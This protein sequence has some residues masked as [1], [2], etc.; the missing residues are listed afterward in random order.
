MHTEKSLH[1]NVIAYWIVALG[2]LFYFY[3]YFLRITPSVIG[4]EL[5]KSFHMD[6][7]MFGQLSA[8]Y[9]YA[10]TPMQLVVGLLIDRFKLRNILGL[11]TLCCVL[12][13]YL[14]ATT[15]HYQMAEFGRFLQ[16]FGS[17][18]AFV[19][20]LKLAAMWLPVKRFGL[21]SG[22]C[23]ALGFFGAA[24]G[25]M[26][27]T[28]FVEHSGWHFVL[29]VFAFAGIILMIALV[30]FVRENKSSICHSPNVRLSFPDFFGQIVA[31]IKKPRIWVAGAL[32]ALMF[33]PT[34]VFAGL[35]G[36]PY[37]C[38][39]HD[40]TRV[41]AG[42][43]SA[44]IFLGWTM[45]APLQGWISDLLQSRVRVIMVG[46]LIGAILSLIVLYDVSLSYFSVCLLF[47]LFGIAS[48]SQVLTFAIARDL[49]SAA[50]A[51]SAIA[52]VNTLAMVGG[53][54]FQKGVGQ[55]LDWNWTGG[56][57][58]GERVYSILSY[59]KSVAIIPV[60]LFIAFLVALCFRQK[61]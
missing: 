15:N 32:S 23:A 41:Q 11:A 47:F 34:T 6:A 37:L 1:V 18:F 22:A 48:S 35:W 38:K 27:L 52:F 12:G 33:M 56:M 24:C 31:V 16:G 36:I 60:F 30:V 49:S 39:I 53:F 19:G 13:T 2:A 28:T 50:I 40:Y 5:M 44:M 8:Y 17:A 14:I 57:H 9:F 58:H 55:L 42:I 21:F 45:G 61:K 25:Q 20:A 46:A 3:E 4:P 54:I 43:A 7:T 51:G 26:L 29:K 59:E 10:Y